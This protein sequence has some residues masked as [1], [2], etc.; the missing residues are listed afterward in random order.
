MP[1]PRIELGADLQQHDALPVGYVATLSWLRHHP[2]GLRR[3]PK[4][5]RIQAFPSHI[6]TVI[7]WAAFYG[8]ASQDLEVVNSSVLVLRKAWS[9][10]PSDQLP[11]IGYTLGSQ[12]L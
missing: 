3:H 7:N 4:F 9:L 2:Y 11:V 8:T 10:T 5:K 1:E 12:F 6:L